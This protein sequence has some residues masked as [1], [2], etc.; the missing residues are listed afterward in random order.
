M[1]QTSKPSRV[2]RFTTLSVSVLEC[3]VGK[4]SAHMTKVNKNLKI[5]KGGHWINVRMN[6][7]HKEGLGV[8]L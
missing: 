8:E 5:S 7:H 4:I 1:A 6:S 3:S 2:T